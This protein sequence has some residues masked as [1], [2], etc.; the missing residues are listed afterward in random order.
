MRKNLFIAFFI[1]KISVIYSQSN[2][3]W[4]VIDSIPKSKMTIYTDTKIF[5]ANNWK[6][7]K[8]V[9]QLDDKDAGVIV[10]KGSSIQK[11]NHQLN[12]F[13]YVYNY[14]V[15][16]RMRDNRFKI[17]LSDVYCDSAYPVGQAEFDILKI[18]PFDGV[19]QKGETGLRT[20]TLPEKK[21][22]PMMA[23]LKSDLQAIV[24]GYVKYIKQDNSGTND[25]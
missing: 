3:K 22:I 1:F 13:T 12:V 5:I 16:F 4:D 25:W 19:Y 20:S 7:A 11:V 18:E 8:S 14:T 17:M 23:T 2:F 9:I 15:T 10:L 21:A 6:S 24:D